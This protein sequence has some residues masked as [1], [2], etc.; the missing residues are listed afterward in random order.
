MLTSKQW[1]VLTQECKIPC[2]LADLNTN[3]IIYVNDEM[4]KLLMGRRE[5][6]GE[7]FFDVIHNDSSITDL[8]FLSHWKCGDVFTC[9]IFDLTLCRSFITTHMNVNWNGAAYHF[10]KLEPTENIDFNFEDTISQCISIIQGEE[11]NKIP[12]LLRIL[13]EFYTAQKAYLY[14]VDYNEMKVPCASFW[15]KSESV[16]IVPDL[17]TK[18]DTQDL[19][20]W[21]KTCNEVGIIEAA[22]HH[23]GENT[24]G[25]VV[26][27]KL[28]LKNIVM[29]VVK[30]D[31][32]EP[33]AIIAVSNRE[34]TMADFRLLQAVTGFLEKDVTEAN[35]A[36]TQM[37]AMD[38][39]TGFY[40]R[41]TY[42]KKLDR[43]RYNPPKQMG[44]VFANINGLR[45]INSE[46]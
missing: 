26:L 13:G 12:S 11:E 15:R 30:N 24:L 34:N 5:I 46:Q 18:L 16:N 2:Y 32:G 25:D 1:E 27:E 41:S 19:L 22:T 21:F 4:R 36:V 29:S 44:V 7:K 9:K 6:V 31:N 37:N 17:S 28:D 38:I 45:K 8:S 20:D 35:L 10:C 3:N 33:L 23:T 42:N 14:Q 43:L 40:S 39:L